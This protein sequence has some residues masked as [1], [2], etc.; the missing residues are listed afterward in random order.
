MWAADMAQEVE[1]IKQ[2]LDIVDVV[3]SYVPLKRAGANYKGVCPFHQEKSP[4][5]MVSQTKQIWHCFG[6]HEGGDVLAF[7]QKIEGMS[8]FETLV[9][10]G[11]RVGVKVQK[12]ADKPGETPDV[13]QRLRELL[14]VTTKFYHAVLTTHPKA[15]AARDYVN[16]RKL[17][18]STIDTFQLGYAPDSWDTLTKFLTTKGYRKEEMVA[19]G[20]VIFNQ[21]RKSYYDRFRHRFMIPLRDVHGNVVG[22]TARAIGD[23]YEGGKYI[24][25]PQTVLYDKSRLVFALDQAKQAIKEAGYA[26]IVEGNMDA[27]SSHQAGVKPV[28]AVSGT[29]FTDAQIAML[30]RFTKTLIFSFDA[31]AAGMLAARRSVELAL[32][33]GMEVKM[34]ILPF[35]KDPDECIQKDVNAWKQSISS[36]KPMLEEII[37][38]SVK[39]HDPHSAQGKK[40][41]YDDVLSVMT[42]VSDP[43][44]I[45][46]YLRILSDEIQT[47]PQVL[48]EELK[49]RTNSAAHPSPARTAPP[50]ATTS[51][52]QTPA[53]PAHASEDEQALFEYLALSCLHPSLLAK[54]DQAWLIQGGQLAEL[55]KYLTS[56][57]SS[58]ITGAPLPDFQAFITSLP[59]EYQELFVRIQLFGDKEYAELPPDEQSATA[60][61]RLL[62]LKKKHLLRELGRIQSA[63]KEAERAG[64]ETSLQQHMRS[65][66]DVSQQLAQLG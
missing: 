51:R 66:S 40:A 62:F 55:Y 38:R 31:D 33:A 44:E 47:Q 59:P 26:V 58:N 5:F 63:L 43:V 45:D 41:I 23:T 15:Q 61:T 53:P 7:V 9:M 20:V 28:V 16:T 1:E 8:F 56:Y 22:F 36:A 2:R 18:Q 34:L 10:L 14:A 49:R 3:Q 52:P 13:K 29:A 54:L 48:F 24:N 65:F 39:R 60:Q 11:E 6:C 19:A 50:T 37:K 4:S 30:K 46:H 42:Y 27:V 57:Y 17:Q 32:K 35:G 21:E 25:T 12:K 64:D